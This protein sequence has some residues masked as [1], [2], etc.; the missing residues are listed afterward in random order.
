MCG[1]AGLTVLGGC[2][3][4]GLVR[5]LQKCLEHRGP[6]DHGFLVQFGTHVRLHR[7]CTAS[8]ANAHA[9]LV[10]RRLAII[11]LAETGW[12]PM[13]TPDGRFHLV[14]NGEIY[15]Y[16]ELR[17]ELERAGEQFSST[18]DSEVLLRAFA[19]WGAAAFS[20][21]IGMFAVAILDAQRRTIALA[22]DCFGIKPLYYTT[23]REG[24][25][26]ASEIK[27]LL[28]LP[29]VARTINASRLYAYLVHGLSDYGAET[30][31]DEVHQ[32]PAAHWLELSLDA[33]TLP[34]PKCYWTPDLSAG[35]DLSLQDAAARLRDLFLE[36]IRLHLR[37]DVPIGVALSGGLD[38][39]SIAMAVRAV[40]PGSQQLHTFSY[41]ADD[42]QLSE[43]RWV[44]VVGSAA[45]AEVHKVRANARELAMDLER[46]T[47]MQDEPF[48]STSIYA[49]YRVFQCAHDAGMKVMLDGQGADELLAGYRGYLAVRLATL[50][51]QGRLADAESFFRYAS[52]LP[53]SGRRWL[54]ARAAGQLLPLSMQGL[55]RRCAGRDP[56]PSWLNR[57]WF[58]ARGVTGSVSLVDRTPRTLQ[59]VLQSAI[60]VTSLPSLLRYE[61]RNSMSFSIESRVP[62]LTPALVNFI[63]SLPEEYLI[64]PDGTSKAVFRQAMRGIVPSAVLDRQDKVGFETTEHSWLVGLRP[65]V[66]QTLASDYAKRIPALNL[67]VIE[68]QWSARLHGSRRMRSVDS[69]VWRWINFI[70]W[71]ERS[72]V[73]FE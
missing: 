46:L 55:P 5:G 31:L 39:S 17:S 4:L 16:L 12:Q 37:S 64:A 36:N 66:E 6:D 38:S 43:E 51:R 44:D 42:P 53:G 35:A 41:V 63:L 8:T 57:A 27:A 52:A 30:L 2:L 23:W 61:D 47:A 10:H 54:G 33:R 50:L 58:R 62:F 49:Q 28:G 70:G 9:A 56:L 7:D 65:W 19:V 67:D 69:P 20:R 15:N 68:R 73:V 26:F 32:L 13:S 60:R 25:A 59:E 45:K 21:F 72:D 29:G 11:D 1:I 24:I 3:D 71:S 18:S 34:E 22:R 14:F 48:G 40:Q